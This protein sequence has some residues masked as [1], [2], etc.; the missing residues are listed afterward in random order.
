MTSSYYSAALGYPVALA[1]VK[2]GHSRIGGSV[3]ACTLDDRRVECE[4]TSPVFYDP[5]GERMKQ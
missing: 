3:Y 5:D 4:I 2:G 1:L